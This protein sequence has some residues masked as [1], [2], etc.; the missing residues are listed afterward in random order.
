V[1]AYE[2]ELPARLAAWEEKVG[3]KESWSVLDPA[4]LSATNNAQLAKQQ[5]LSV[6]VTG[7]NG[8]GTYQFVAPTDV[9]GITGVRLEVLRDDRLPAKGP[10]R[11]P[12]GNFVLTEFRVEWAPANAPEKRRPVELQNAQADFSQQNYNVATAIDKQDA[13]T[14][15]GWATSPKFGENRTAVFET[16]SSTPT[17]RGRL[18]FSLVQNYQDGQHSIGRFRI[19]VTNAPRPIRLDGLPKNITD[20]L[21]IAVDQRSDKQKQDLA[22]FYRGIDEE[23]KRRQQAL[24]EAKKPRPVDPELEKLRRQLA[25][26]SKPLPLDPQL[27]ELRR[28]VELSAKQLT[29]SRLTFAQDLTWALINN[30]A[31]LFNR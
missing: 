26:A 15:N 31:F 1:Q 28:S 11:A 3:G 10:G 7:P 2:K 5:D 25:D 23:L 19:S 4:E 16:K 20:V 18:S 30:P 13:A 27:M 14:N 9:G 22:S 29:E 6:W 24:A 8:K 12:N 17:E 21:A